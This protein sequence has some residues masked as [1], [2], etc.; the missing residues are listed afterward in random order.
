MS[1]PAASR[2]KR[3]F[4]SSFN[5]WPARLAVALFLSSW[6]ASGPPAQAEDEINT[7]P[8]TATGRFAQTEIQPGTSATVVIEMK[9]DKGYHA[10]VERFKLAVGKPEDTAVGELVISPQVDF[11]DSVSKTNKKGIKGEGVIH[12]R[13][14]F[15]TGIPL[16]EREVLFKLTYQACA[17]DHCLFP[18]TIEVAAPVRFVNS[19]KLGSP[20][21][22]ISASQPTSLA[23]NPGAQNAFEKSLDEG[24]FAAL[25][26]V[27]LVGFAT[28]LTPCVYPMIPITLAVLGARAKGQSKLRSFS[29]SVIY[30]LG[31]ATTYSALGVFAASTGSLFGAALSNVYVV[32]AMAGLFVVM[33]LS[34]YGLFE[35]QPPAFIR[36]RLGAG[37]GAPGAV[38]AYGT[39][40][41]AGVVASPCVGP[42]L[43]SVLTWIAQT[44][45]LFY[46]FLFLFTFAI[47]MGLLFIALG[48]SSS[49]IGK[50][51][52]S[53][54]WMD[55]VK[56]LFGTTMVA[57][58]IYYI[59]PIYPSW[60]TLSLS[61]L[62]IVL[63]ASAYG[64]FDGEADLKTGFSRVRKGFL[65]ASFFV[66]VS[67]LV[68]SLLDRTGALP[69]SALRSS[70]SQASA[71]GLSG[72][73][74]AKLPWVPYSDAAIKQARESN[75]PVLI[76]FYAD[77]CGACKELEKYTFTDAQVRDLSKQFALF[78]VDAT[79][80]FPGLEEI[81]KKYQVFGLP[82]LIF[83]D[84][85]GQLRSDL[86]L[87]GFEDAQAFAARMRKVL[88]SSDRGVASSAP[89]S[90]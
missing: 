55:G 42:V 7:N 20:G 82:T 3:S 65:L 88:Q 79:E 40:L 36:N 25:A 49:L 57:M 2:F 47:G 52:K 80:S 5:A 21:P 62:A 13:V 27:F 53:G 15:P 46:G 90:P 66:G 87:N 58:A 17:E 39:G 1:C 41:V 44:Q 9:I 68:T 69:V 10:Y 85:S 23:V 30:V 63:I 75:R 43:V 28:S 86:T 76:D 73:E 19:I 51:P 61:G 54:G 38:G 59:T 35:L 4:S 34:M 16:N 14:D 45:N 33:G 89:S 48:T 11:F 60:L 31:I 26:F 18:K 81:K 32:T 70:S 50:L 8:L 29:L 78:K 12:A 56:F 64:A 37:Q 84:Q 83:Y 77:W 72:G 6:L 74:I 67:L 22:Q 71:T 24:L